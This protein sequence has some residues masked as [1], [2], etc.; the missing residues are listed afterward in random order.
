[1]VSI[2]LVLKGDKSAYQVNP[3]RNKTKLGYFHTGSLCDILPHLD[4][5]FWKVNGLPSRC[6]VTCSLPL[7]REHVEIKELA[8]SADIKPVS[9]LLRL[10]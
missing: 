1:M 9:S 5:L 8:G 3:R 10:Q 7:A 6:V 2:L 4:H